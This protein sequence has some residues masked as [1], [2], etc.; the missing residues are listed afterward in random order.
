MLFV[1]EFYFC[2]NQSTIQSF[3]RIIRQRLQQCIVESNKAHAIPFNIFKDAKYH[4][5]KTLGDQTTFRSL[6]T[7]LGKSIKIS[8]VLSI[9]K[10]C[11]KL[12]Q[13][14]C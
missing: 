11:K 14:M 13:V 12:T 10:K 3:A 5:V 7:S 1:F 9:G 2:S 4:C 6:T 8:I